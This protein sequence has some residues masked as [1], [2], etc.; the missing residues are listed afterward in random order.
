MSVPPATEMFQFAGFASRTYRFGAGYHQNKSG[1]GLPH[2]DTPGSPIARISPGLFAACRVLPRLSTP[3]HP[4]DALS[5]AH[6]HKT[7]GRPRHPMP[8]SPRSRARPDPAYLSTLHE[9]T[10]PREPTAPGTKPSRRASPRSLATPSSPLK[11]HPA[12]K[13]GRH[14]ISLPIPRPAP[15]WAPCPGGGALVEVNGFEPMTSCLQSRRS[16]S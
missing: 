7:A 4:P 12:A 9:D 14:Q 13:S 6:P 1:G 16:P 5:C 8:G 10:A 2:S 15:G 3:R 11:Q